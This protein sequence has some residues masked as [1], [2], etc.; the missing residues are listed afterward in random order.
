MVEY[1]VTSVREFVKLL[2][3]LVLFTLLI[4]QL[5]HCEPSVSKP[6]RPNSLGVDQL[7]VNPNVYLFG[8]PVGGELIRGERNEI[9]TSVRFQP[10]NTMAL[11]DESVLFCGDVAHDFNNKQGALVVTY[12]RRASRSFHGIGCHNLDSVFVVPSP[13]EVEDSK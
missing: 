8:S 1:P 2:L 11:Y 10:Y 13:K 3:C 4:V 9:Y 5:A 12:S 6:N 7:Y